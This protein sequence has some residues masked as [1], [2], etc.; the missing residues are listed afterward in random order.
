MTGRV[1]VSA[2][3]SMD[4][5]VIVLGAGHNGLVCANDL[6]AGGLRVLVLERRDVLG[7]AA[8][9]E[10]FWPGFRNSS[11]SYTVSLLHPDIIRDL[12]LAE[13]GL[14]IV[15]R[16][17]SNFLPTEDGR[18]LRYGGDEASQRS[19]ASFSAKDAQAL[20]AQQARLQV[21]ARLLRDW[22]LRAPPELGGRWLVAD[23]RSA[24]DAL[25]LARQVAGLDRSAQRD[26]MH[27]FTRSA[28]HWL[29]EVFES[30]VLK[31]AM[32]FDAVVGN[33]A[34]PYAAGSAY[35][36]L[37]HWFGGVNGK[38]GNWG[39]AIGGM[40]RITS[41]MADEALARG[42]RIER[43]CEVARVLVEAGRVTGVA[44]SDG[45]EFHAPIVAAAVNPR[46]LYDRLIDPA[47]L[48]ADFAQA[49]RGYRG[50]SGTLR[51]NVA[52]SELPDFS[53]CPGTH[54]QDHHA[55]GIVFAPSL[56]FMDQ[57]WRDAVAQGYARRPIVEMLI[58]STVDDTLAPPGQHVASLF[59][60]HF[61][62][63]LRERWD[64]LK[65]AAVE[66]I[67]DVVQ[68]HCP[69]FR[70][71][72]LGYKAWSPMDLERVYGLIDG[73]IFHGQ[74]SLNQLFSFR[75]VMGHARYAG[76]IPGLFHCAS[77]S[78]PGGGVTGAP[79][80]NAARE[81]LRAAGR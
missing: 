17:F 80:R 44:L 28:G 63:A 70:R 57:A 34:S 47:D 32:G 59:C 21:L 27:L 1:G 37:H 25:D 35:V 4:A 30:D 24:R 6:A 40:G 29:D 52:L 10:E 33:F 14:R 18:Y 72:L 53:V 19:I 46:L 11:A 38:E 62:P 73:D 9:T 15:E 2:R 31:A 81:I 56:A 16:P 58:P 54:R 79:G 67:F 5:D 66:A 78:H 41:L 65:P 50:G 23:W 39:H 74:L 42:V 61:D 64:E 26:L 60:Q 45:R 49:I 69:N 36:L 43:E 12:H 7:G 76:P 3:A 20:P 71:S 75:P 48:D 68:S 8:V 55:S 13:R 51:L 22:I 77:G